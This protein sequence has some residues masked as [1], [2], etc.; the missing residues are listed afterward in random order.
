MTKMRAQ[1]CS[2]YDPNEILP[3]RAKNQLMECA[4]T[5]TPDTTDFVAGRM[6]NY[7]SDLGVFEDMLVI[8]EGAYREMDAVFCTNGLNSMEV[9]Y[10]DTQAVWDHFKGTDKHRLRRVGVEVL[11]YSHQL[12]Y[13]CSILK[14][15]L[16]SLQ[17]YWIFWG[18]WRGMPSCITSKRVFALT[19]IYGMDLAI[20]LRSQLKD[21]RPCNWTLEVIF[22]F[23]HPQRCRYCRGVDKTVQSMGS[24]SSLLLTTGSRWS[25]EWRLGCPYQAQT[26]TTS[27]SKHRSD[28]SIAD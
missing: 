12:V 3:K 9:T 10:K 8:L 17:V 14:R 5:V 28:L 7:H 27:R 16:F 2:V 4:R 11:R 25:F 1:I 26:E 21:F 15:Y 20:E 18:L 24:K 13:F 6:V 19:L 23:R 22:F